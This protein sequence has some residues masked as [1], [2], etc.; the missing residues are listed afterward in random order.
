MAVSCGT[1]SRPRMAS[2]IE[3]ASSFWR[4]AAPHW[5]AQRR[6]PRRSRAMGRSSTAARRPEEPSR[7]QG[8]ACLRA[9]MVRPWSDSALTSRPLSLVPDGRRA[10]SAGRQV[11]GHERHST[12]STWPSPG[13]PDYPARGRAVCGHGQAAVHCPSPK[14]PTQSPC[15]GCE[16]WYDLHDE[17]HMELRCKPWEWPCVVRRAGSARALP[18]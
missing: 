9:F 12:R 18:A 11:V 2:L 16:R 17:L 4:N 8:R 7:C 10:A 13:G 1:R 5:T 14:P 3:V 6:S 15:P